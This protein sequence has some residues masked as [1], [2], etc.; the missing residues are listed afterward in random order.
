M[1][2]QAQLTERFERALV[3][4]CQVHAGQV[5][6]GN[7]VPYLSHLLAVSAL[8]LEFGGNED[9]A[10]GGLLHDA[11]EDAG[12]ER[13][14]DEI[15]QQFG[16]SVAEIVAGCTE[17]LR[18]PKPPWRVRKE[19]FLL[20]LKQA[21]RSVLLVVGSDKLHNMRCTIR[22][23][24][25]QGSQFW[26]HFNCSKPE[27]LWYFRSLQEVFLSRSGQLP[28]ALLEELTQTL[29]QLQKLAAQY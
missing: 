28:S 5:R 22:G 6:K 8:V 13:R 4:T 23:L 25:Q 2:G 17:T 14:L 19:E 26:S 15:C 9:E 3:Y 20:R 7:N 1:N 18:R 12:G 21:S 11:V 27:F 24:H 16:E 29:D 10:I